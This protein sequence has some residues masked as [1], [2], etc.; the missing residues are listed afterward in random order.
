MLKLQLHE[1][2]VLIP[3]EH[4]TFSMIL[5]KRRKEPDES[6]SSNVAIEE[7]GLP[8]WATRQDERSG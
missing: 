8:M 6:D 7:K 4:T 1:N 3:Y 5:F 2:E